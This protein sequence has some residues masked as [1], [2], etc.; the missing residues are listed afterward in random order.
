M[1][2]IVVLHSF[3]NFLDIAYTR[4]NTHTRA[5]THTRLPMIM[6]TMAPRTIKMV[7]MKSVHMTAERPPV[8]QKVAA[9]T[10]KIKMEKYKPE[11]IPYIMSLHFSDPLEPLFNKVNL[12]PPQTLLWSLCL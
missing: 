6:R 3:R 8:M 10:S 12:S 4:L 1:L 11:N 2:A 5:H 7:W 9:R